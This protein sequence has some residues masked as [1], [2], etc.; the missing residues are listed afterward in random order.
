LSFTLDTEATQDH[1]KAVVPSPQDRAESTAARQSDQSGQ[2]VPLRRNDGFRLLLG[3]SS[4][5]LLGSRVTT[6]AYPL[7]ALAISGSPLLAGWA[8]FAATAPSV[9]VYLPAGAIVD[10]CNPRVAMF[11][12][13]TVR[14]LAILSVVV[15]IMSRLTVLLLITAAVIEEIFEVFSNL[16]ERRLTCSLVEP[17]NVPSAL[18]GTEARTHLAV[19]LGRP[20]GALL[21]GVSHIAPF[22]FDSFTFGANAATLLKMRKHDRYDLGARGPR[23]NLMREITEGVRWLSHDSFARIA[24]PL[25]AGTTFVGQALIMFFLVQAHA[26]HL[27]GLEIGMVLAGSGLGG[28]LGGLAAPRLFGSLAYTLLNWQLMGWVVTFTWVYQWGWQSP[29]C[30]AAAM[31]FMSFTGALGNVALDNYIAQTAGPTLLGRVMSIYSLIS[32]AALAVGPL[33][34][35]TLLSKHSPRHA[36]LALLFV[37]VFL[38]AMQPHESRRKT[39]DSYGTAFCRPAAIRVVLSLGRLVAAR[40]GARR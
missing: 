2:S 31:M 7:L 16:A 19:M 3:G 36:V 20:L 5:S 32:F 9:L 1:R 10:R 37:V 38:W 6:I 18:A 8:C 12:C 24:V 21:F 17:G 13:E 29:W 11:V 34:G 15:L 35:A 40:S 23:A 28:A 14:G 39:R 30:I 25:T 22:A 26:G 33:I 27:S 4:L